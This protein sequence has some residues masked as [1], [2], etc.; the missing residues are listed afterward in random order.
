MEQYK[1]ETAHKITLKE[2]KTLPYIEQEGW[3]SNYLDQQGKKIVRINVMAI[4]ISTD[5]DSSYISLTL[6]DASDNMDARFFE[7]QQKA[8]T[9]QPGSCVMI[10]GKPRAFGEERYIVGETVQMIDPLWLKC[11]RAE[12][13]LTMPPPPPVS[14]TPSPPSTN[15]SPT[16]PSKSPTKTEPK[17]DIDTFEAIKQKDQGQGVSIDAII[18]EFG[19][20]KEKEINE[21]LSKGEIFEIKPG[22]VKV[23]E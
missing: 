9:I 21:L 18:E 19:P 16:P 20:E 10:T 2:I 3:N 5:T 8:T 22:V 13:A 14:S 7:M 1:R 15:P 11:R 23:L 4:V 17:K 6:D 12:L